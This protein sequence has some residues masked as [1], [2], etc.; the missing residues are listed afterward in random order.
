MLRDIKGILFPKDKDGNPLPKIDEMSSATLAEALASGGGDQVVVR[1]RAMHVAAYA[2]QFLFLT[3][4][5]RQPV[6]SLSGG[7]RNRLLLACALA[8]T[9]TTGRQ[10]PAA[11]PRFLPR[12]TRPTEKSLSY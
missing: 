4:Q 1:G 3:S 9:A 5:L 11:G 10:Q 12:V 8:R 6:A 7:E 2:K